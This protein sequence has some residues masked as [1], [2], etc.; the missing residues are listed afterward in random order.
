MGWGVGGRERQLITPG[1]HSCS[2]LPLYQLNLFPH[3]LGKN[4]NIETREAAGKTPS[5]KKG[6]VFSCHQL[7]WVCPSRV[8]RVG[9]DE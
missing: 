4:A 6:N 3:Q 5:G 1:D 8:T 9:E 2:T 7:S